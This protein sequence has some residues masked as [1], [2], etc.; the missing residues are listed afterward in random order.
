MAGINKFNQYMNMYNSEDY[1]LFSGGAQLPSMSS[2]YSLSDYAAI[3]NGSYGKA[4]K[5]YYKKMDAEKLSFG[6]D[7]AQ[8]NLL[9]KSGADALE[10]SAEALKKDTLFYGEI[11]LKQISFKIEIMEN[12]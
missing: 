7:S 4:L 5:A 12:M 3:K 11:I 8:K 2:S 6:A 9:M 1:S 10:K